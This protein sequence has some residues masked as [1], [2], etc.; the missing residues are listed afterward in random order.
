MSNL[1]H[2]P[3][4]DLCRLPVVFAVL[5][6]CQ[7]LVIIYVLSLTSI[8]AFNWELLS[9]LTLYAQWVCLLALAGLCQ[10]RRW[11]NRQSIFVAYALSLM[12]ILAV[13]AITNAAA[14]WLYSGQRWQWSSQWLMRDLM[15]AAVLAGVVLRYIFIQQNWLAEQ[16]ATQSA[17]LDA[18][19]ARIR[20]HFLFNTM[21]TIASL[22]AYA[23]KDAERAVEDLAALLRATLSDGRQIVPW[24]QELAICEAYLRIEQLRLGERLQVSWQ[25]DDVPANFQ[26]PPLVLQPLIENAIYHGI[27]QHPDGGCINIEAFV[28]GAEVVLSIVNPVYPQAVDHALGSKTSS[29][30]NGLALD[31]ISARLAS[32]YRNADTGEQLAHLEMAKSEGEFIARLSIPQNSQLTL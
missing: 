9:L 5:A 14:Q 20:P 18:L 30:H 22:I 21:N 2:T 27:E 29:R 15:I 19:H 16:R 31:N 10:L 1:D 13:V 25:V 12:W 11:L 7:L 17:M 4:P 26:L 3:L 32:I 24:P 8:K 23:P 28:D 6:V